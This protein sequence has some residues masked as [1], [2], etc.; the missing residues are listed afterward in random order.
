M[1]RN[2]KPVADPWIMAPKASEGSLA[3]NVRR[4]GTGVLNI[5]RCRVGLRYPGNLVLSHRDE[6]GRECNPSCPIGDQRERRVAH[7]YHQNR[8]ESA[9]W[10]SHCQAHP[11]HALPLPIGNSAGRGGARSLLWLGLDRNRHSDGRLPVRRDQR[12]ATYADRL[13]RIRNAEPRQRFGAAR[14][15]RL[16]PALPERLRFGWLPVGR[17]HGAPGDR[18]KRALC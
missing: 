16:G 4:W 3:E 6:C 10:T 17:R 5:D 11:A 18:G 1:W 8:T 9:E 15:R 12:R 13:R 7:Y 14:A 2:L